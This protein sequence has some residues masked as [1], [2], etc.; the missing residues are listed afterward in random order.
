SRRYLKVRLAEAP[1]LKTDTDPNQTQVERV[2]MSVIALDPFWYGDETVIEWE[3]PTDTTGVVPESVT[4]SG[5]A[6]ENPGDFY[7]WPVYELQAA[8]GARWILPDYS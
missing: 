5:L 1:Q 7:S 2:V 3:N 4:L 6:F 8:Q